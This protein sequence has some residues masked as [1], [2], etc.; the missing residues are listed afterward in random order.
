MKVSPLFEPCRIS[1]PERTHERLVENR[2]AQV[3]E[4]LHGPSVPSHLQDLSAQGKGLGSG[5]DDPLA[6]SKRSV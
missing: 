1:S 2:N 3:E 6:M 5:A 4:G